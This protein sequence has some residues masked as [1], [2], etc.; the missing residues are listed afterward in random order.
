MPE[1]RPRTHTSERRN[2]HLRRSRPYHKCLPKYLNA[3]RANGCTKP[4]PHPAA[5]GPGGTIMA[6]GQRM[7]RQGQVA[8]AAPPRGHRRQCRPLRHSAKQE[9]SWR[10][11]FVIMALADLAPACWLCFSQKQQRHK[12]L[13]SGSHL[14]RE[15]FKSGVAWHGTSPQ[16]ASRHLGRRDP[17][18]LRANGKLFYLYGALCR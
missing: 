3:C 12:P 14:P 10:L 17:I 1:Y 15:A 9:C 8:M 5:P 13:L 6:R 18:P 2:Y 16:S 7:G 4:T 11:R